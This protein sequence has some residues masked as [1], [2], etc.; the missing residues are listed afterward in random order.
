[1]AML[2]EELGGAT[3][4]AHDTASGLEAFEEYQPDIV[5]LDIGMPGIDGYEAC[6][7]MRQRPS[8]A[9]VIVAV[10]GG[11]RRKTNSGRS[12]PASM[13]IL[14]NPSTSRR[15]HASSLRTLQAT[16]REVCTASSL[17]RSTVLVRA[18]G[19]PCASERLARES[20]QPGRR[21]STRPRHPQALSAHGRC[22]PRSRGLL[23]TAAVRH[24]IIELTIAA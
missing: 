11:D 19:F 12:K 18:V 14:Q 22:P 7:R 8:K 24:G 20:F 4:M 3:R 9:I 23:G 1:M 13:R 15:W 16:P 2:L 5:F 21:R 17:N 6:R 10:T